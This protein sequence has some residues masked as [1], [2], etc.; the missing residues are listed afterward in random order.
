MKIPHET[1][2]MTILG[3]LG[4]R[5]AAMFRVIWFLQEHRRISCFSNMVRLYILRAVP[6]HFWQGMGIVVKYFLEYKA[7]NLSLIGRSSG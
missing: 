5:F 7:W 1:Q 3:D 4:L 2:N 6:S